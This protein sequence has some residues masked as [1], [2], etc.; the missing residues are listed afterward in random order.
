MTL[1]WRVILDEEPRT[2]PWNMAL[3]EALARCLAPGEGVLRFYAWSPHTI[4]FGRNEPARGLYDPGVAA[5]EGL[6]FVRRPTGGRAVLH[7]R[8]VTYAAVLPVRA[9]GGLRAAYL[10]INEGLVKGL[11]A[12]GAPAQVSKDGMVVGPDAGPC[13]QVPAPGEVILGGRKL[14]GSAQVRLGEAILQHGS[15]ILE[16]DQSR[17]M[18]VGGGSG[19]PTP[20]A[21]LAEFLGPV[22][23]GSVAGA[24]GEGLELALGGVWEQ[25]GYTPAETA[26]AGVLENDPYGTDA[27]TWRL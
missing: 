2:G 15:V 6:A 24:L 18:R 10:R 21:A 20:P 17:L 5:R 11:H 26:K 9:L 8:E 7:A 27:W 1:R 16:G 25:G 12:L 22:S 13:F 19:D 23:W 3:D 14:V 4:S